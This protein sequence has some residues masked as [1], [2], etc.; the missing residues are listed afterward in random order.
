MSHITMTLSPMTLNARVNREYD[1]LDSKGKERVRRMVAKVAVERAAR[2][3]KEKVEVERIKILQRFEERVQ[4]AQ[5]EAKDLSLVQ[6]EKEV[7]EAYKIRE[8]QK[9]ELSQGGLV[10]FGN[11]LQEVLEQQKLREEESW[12]KEARRMKELFV[13]AECDRENLMEEIKLL[14]EVVPEEVLRDAIELA[15]DLD[16]SW[17]GLEALQDAIEVALEL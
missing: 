17:E 6:K 14:K 5:E 16:V 4:K 9:R 13:I 10:S 2:A 12:L 7:E 8:A 11:Q 15:G 3:K 1:S